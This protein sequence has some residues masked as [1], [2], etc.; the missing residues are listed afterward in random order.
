MTRSAIFDL[1][2]TLAHT[3]P[4][5]IGAAND[6]LA[7][8]GLPAMPLSV[9]E[10]TAGYG[11]KA[12]IRKSHELAGREIT[13][14]RVDALYQPFLQRYAER[15]ADES[16]LYEGV[17]QVLDALAAD[18]WLLAVCTNKPEAL[19]LALLE[20]LGVLDRFGTLIGADTLP[21][22]KP[23][24]RTLFDTIARVGGRPEAAVMI[25]DTDTDLK[26]ARNAE[27][28]CILTDFGYSQIPV[29]TLKP[30]VVVSTFATIP[31]AL[32]RLT[33][34]RDPA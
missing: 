26:T 21:Y 4:D 8:D 22:R 33:T 28:P 1:D 19:A 17:T 9:A 20:K 25:G 3:A 6:L 34:T 24:P 32:D 16:M 23:D 31:N 2:G 12:L 15:I 18:G 10:S 30:D 11:A 27:V 5:L 29:R 13:E 14:Q 7:G